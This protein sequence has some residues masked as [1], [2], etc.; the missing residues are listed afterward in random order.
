MKKGHIFIIIL[1]FVFVIIFI[2]C[3]NKNNE[4]ITVENEVNNDLSAKIEEISSDIQYNKFYDQVQ[5]QQKELEDYLLNNKDVIKFDNISFYDFNSRHG[6]ENILFYYYLSKW[7][8]GEDKYEIFIQIGLVKINENEYIIYLEKYFFPFPE[9]IILH[10][11]AVFNGDKFIFKTLDGWDN[12]VVGNFTF[13]EDNVL[14]GMECERSF[15]IIGKNHTGRQ[16]GADLYV[17]KKSNF[18]DEK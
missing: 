10:T 8:D 15:D 1:Q 7:Y 9:Y 5:Q 17:L 6:E 11:R 2:F 12:I 4:I 13:N 18:Y 14:L 16:Y 3:K